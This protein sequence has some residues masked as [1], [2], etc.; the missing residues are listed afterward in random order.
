M[1]EKEFL[2]V[3]FFISK[4]LSTSIYGLVLIYVCHFHHLL[5]WHFLNF[6]HY[7]DTRASILD[8]CIQGILFFKLISRNS[9]FQSKLN[10]SVYH[11]LINTQWYNS[12]WK[13]LESSFSQIQFH[14]RNIEQFVLRI[15]FFEHF[16]LKS[17]VEQ[18]D[19]HIMSSGPFSQIPV[20]YC[21]YEIKSLTFF[22]TST[23]VFVIHSLINHFFLKSR[24]IFHRFLSCESKY[25]CFEKCCV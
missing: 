16:F 10:L 17:F 18:I 19:Y 23:I 20:L 11:A 13:F 8:P 1:R 7:R 24:R 25:Y 22:S 14:D 9:N 5:L 12:K 3:I 4:N 21:S 15:L 2:P 6:V